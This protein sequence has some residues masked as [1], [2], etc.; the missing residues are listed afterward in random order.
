MMSRATVIARARKGQ[1][2]VVTPL[3]RPGA[4]MVAA[5]AATTVLDDK[6]VT[7]PAPRRCAPAQAPATQRERACPR[8][9]G[10]A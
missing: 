8:T 10:S 5:L 4:W 2:I 6:A 9:D 3:S 1:H 7:L